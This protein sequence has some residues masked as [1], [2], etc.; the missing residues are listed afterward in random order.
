MS[1]AAVDKGASP[2]TGQIYLYFAPLTLLVY[3]VLPNGYL[4]DIV[5]TYMLKNQLHATAVQVSTFRVLTAIPVYLAFVFGLARDLWNPL[6]RRDRGYLFLFAPASA[7]VFLWMAFSGL[8]YIGLLAGMLL[9]MVTFRFVAAAYW[10][11]IALVGQERLMSGRMSALW[12]IVGSLPYI[13]GA[14]ASGY[15]ADNL[16]PRATFILVAALTLCIAGL[17]LWKPRAV[18]DAGYER[19]APKRVDLWGDVKRLLKHRAIYPA[20]LMIFMFQFSPGSNTPLQYYLSNTLH[21]RDEVYGLYQAIFAASFI[22]IF[23]LYG[24]L[25][26]KVSL[27]KL[28]WWGLI[29]TVPQMVPLAFIHTGTQALWLAVPIGMMGGV[30]AAAIYDLAMRSCPPGLQGTMMM[31]IEAG[32]QL[33]FRGGDLLGSRIYASNP[34]H[35]FLYCVI[36]TT[37]V[38]AL[39]VPVILLVPKALIA[40]TDGETSAVLAPPN[41]LEIAET[42]PAAG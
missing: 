31:L 25:C 33:S 27:D 2:P 15:I 21:A 32:N 11:L 36:A 29:I 20:V 6:G 8:S 24:W 12:N 17:G 9:V 22:P 35:G 14:A 13:A 16:T 7:A 41:L 38:Y 42:A 37:A 3:L 30:A 28:L 4:V 10:G 19:A 1:P 34:A 39:I 40:T 26:K 5:T 18:F 23:F